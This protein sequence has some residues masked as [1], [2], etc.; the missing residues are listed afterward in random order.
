MHLRGEQRPL[1]IAR[2]GKSC[3]YRINTVI[4]LT[5]LSSRTSDVALHGKG[6]PPES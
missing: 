1:N 4:F 5:S 3:E 6:L 2:S